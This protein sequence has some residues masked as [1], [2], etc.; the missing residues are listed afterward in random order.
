MNS[1][2][3]LLNESEGTYISVSAFGKKLPEKKGS[4]S[5]LDTL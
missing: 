1:Q 4:K 3:L 5:D 2:E